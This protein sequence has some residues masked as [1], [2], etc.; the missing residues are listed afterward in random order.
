[1]SKLK[2]KL[3]TIFFIDTIAVASMYG[4]NHIVSSSAL[5]KNILKP[6][7]GKYYNWKMGK[8]FYRT[9]GTGSP[10]LL[11]HDLDAFSSGY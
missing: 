3:K 11:I 2:S 9:M 5:L 7:S 8:I 4:I 10:L 6:N 1:M